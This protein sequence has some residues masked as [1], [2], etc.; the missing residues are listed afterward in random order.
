MYLAIRYFRGR[1]GGGGMS[2]RIVRDFGPEQI[3]V[4]EDDGRVRFLPGAKITPE[5]MSFDAGYVVDEWTVVDGVKVITKATLFEVSIA[6]LYKGA[7]ASGR[8][9]G[10]LA[11]AE[12][13]LRWF[14]NYYNGLRLEMDLETA[15]TL[16]RTLSR[17]LTAWRKRTATNA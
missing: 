17:E 1:Y 8:M 11:K 9:G 7:A 6:K 4:I 14:L 10:R 12:S 13:L 5:D 16:S 3:G 15:R 2:V